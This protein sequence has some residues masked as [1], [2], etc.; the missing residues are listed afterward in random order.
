MLANSNPY[1][2]LLPAGL[3]R[4]DGGG[5]AFASRLLDFRTFL[6][7]LLDLFECVSLSVE[8]EST[9]VPSIWFAF[10][11]DLLM[12]GSSSDDSE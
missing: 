2:T 5:E 6:S 7:L 11:L 10:L 12:S 3:E 9:S 8:A 1:Y 4:D